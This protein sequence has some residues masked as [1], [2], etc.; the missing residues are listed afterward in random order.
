MVDKVTFKMPLR[1]NKELKDVK[2]IDAVKKE[3]GDYLVEEILHHV[4]S[5]KSPVTGDSFDALSE[6]Y[7]KFKSKI[8]SNPIP[9]MELFGDMLDSLKFEI[10]RTGIEVGIF[11]SEQAK[12]ADNH[13]KFSAK[14]KGTAV[15]KRQ[16]IPNKKEKQNFHKNILEEVEKIIKDNE[17]AN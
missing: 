13:N 4:G 3:I 12:K 5:A 6:K 8:S 7:K 17:D 15:P 14:S 1:K 9:N 16:F 10:T 2:D 11:D